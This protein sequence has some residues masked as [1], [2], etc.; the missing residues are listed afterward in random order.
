MTLIELPMSGGCQCGRH[1]YTVSALPFTLYACHCTDC[2]T[3]STSAFGMSM[4]VA[5][6]AVSCEFDGLGTWER[7]AAS[8]RT[9][10][11]RYCNE[12]GTRLFHE[13]SRNPK[14]I[15]IKPGTLDNTSWIVPVGHLWL[16]SAQAWFSPPSNA[17]RYEGQPPDFD[18]LSERF[19]RTF[20]KSNFD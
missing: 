19:A 11:A 3:Q 8:G 18:D 16:A 7:T 9:V 6:E 12:C 1:R 10:K 13:P 2:Q 4:P 17:L 5:K 20:G 14:I 15:N